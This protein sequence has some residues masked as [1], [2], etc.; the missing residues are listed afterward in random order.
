M[1]LAADLH[2]HSRY[3][4]AVSPA[5]TVEN[6]SRMAQ[7]KGLDLL[8]TGDCLQP[9]WLQEIEAAMEEAEP[10]LFTLKPEIREK[11]AAKVPA[12]IQR[13]LRF[14]LSTEVCCAPPG[15]RPRGGIHHLIYFPSLDSVRRF[16]ERLARHGDL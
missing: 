4:S 13:Q 6:I 1:H 12:G 11:V 2:L 10:G 16:R 9:D 8:A 14:V 7:L 5:M 3:A 15:T